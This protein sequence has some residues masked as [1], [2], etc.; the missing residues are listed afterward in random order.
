MEE[1][2]LKELLSPNPQNVQI[3]QNLSLSVLQK[4]IKYI[5]EKTPKVWLDNHSIKRSTTDLTTHL[6]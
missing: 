5:L 2:K 6:T 4:V 1:H 3:W